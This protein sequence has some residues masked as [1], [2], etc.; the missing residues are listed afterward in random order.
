MP[1]VKG[2]HAR[3]RVCDET[4]SGL[5]AAVTPRV[6]A[7][8]SAYSVAFGRALVCGAKRRTCI[9]TSARRKL[10]ADLKYNYMSVLAH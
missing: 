4:P 6:A 9:K 3:A 7:F 10:K 8:L 5:A 1:T 2:K